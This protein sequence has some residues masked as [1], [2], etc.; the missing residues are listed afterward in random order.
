MTA[1]LKKVMIGLVVA[2]T[3]ASLLAPDAPL[4]VLARVLAAISAIAV[5][6]VAVKGYRVPRSL[7]SHLAHPDP[8][9][10]LGIE[11]GIRAAVDLARIVGNLGE[12]LDPSATVTGALVG[13]ALM[14]LPGYALVQMMHQRFGDRTNDHL[15]EAVIA[16]GTVSLVFWVCIFEPLLRVAGKET[17]DGFSNVIFVTVA[18]VLTSF[19][20][21]LLTSFNE[22]PAAYVALCAARSLQTAAGLTAFAGNALSNGPLS[23]TSHGLPVIAMLLLALGA[24]HPSMA[25]YEEPSGPAGARLNRFRLAALIVPVVLGPLVLT[26]S[27]TGVL[28]VSPLAVAAFTVGLS[29]LVVGHLISMVQARA[30]STHWASHDKLTGLP[31]RAL[32]RERLAQALERS[33]K[34]G[35]SLSVLY[36]DL[37]RFK[38][39]NDSMGHEAG[40]QLLEQVARR[41]LACADSS[42]TV[43]RLGGDEF[44]ILLPEVE[45]DRVP[46]MLARRLLKTFA[47]PYNL[48]PRPV[49]MSPSIGIAVGDASTPLET[50]LTQAD[51]AMYRAK[52]SGR[53]NFAVWSKEMNEAARQRLMLE[54]QLHSVIT[55]DELRLVYQPKVELATGRVVGVE[56]LIRWHHPKLG[57]I[58]PA[59]FIHLA[60]ESGLI[61]Q[62]GE[63]VLETACRQARI[64]YDNGFTSLTMAVNLSSRQFQQQRMADLVS[65][66]LRQ[67][68]LEP[69]LLELELTESVAMSGEG[70]T[71]A[72]L[73]ELREMG[74]KCSID[75]FGTG[76]SNL[77][78]LSRFPIDSLKIDKSFIEQIDKSGGD[79]AIVV[80]IIAMAHGLNLKVIA[81][82]VETPEQAAFLAKHDCDQLQGFLFSKP[83]S[84]AE[85]EGLLM[86][87]HV[88]SG[89]G[90]LGIPTVDAPR[91]LERAMPE[92]DRL[93]PSTKAIEAERRTEARPPSGPDAPPFARRPAAPAPAP[94]Q[95]AFAQQADRAPKPAMA[96]ARSAAPQSPL[97]PAALPEPTRHVG[98]E[99][100]TAP[101]NPEPPGRE[102][103]R[104]RPTSAP[105]P[106]AAQTE[107][108]QSSPPP[109]NTPVR[110]RRFRE[111]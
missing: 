102:P 46:R 43:A 30:S 78:Y 45:D 62:I 103:A 70:I 5:M 12:S 50:L 39:I 89:Q 77:S 57:V 31:N 36:L 75:D 54:T 41:V 49:F 14:L 100:G 10:I 59:V 23:A 32:F 6:A 33:R 83:L 51:T 108:A 72:T 56:A 3:A 22:R 106:P 90:R 40:D 13:A 95:Q 76:Y 79:A 1:L 65:R 74:V 19:A 85:L 37:D 69:H 71:I 21:H 94:A 91:R 29:L 48:K 26:L 4:V 81:E 86:L 96:V 42:D 88:A 18:L 20:V 55:N 47:T 60:E 58:S 38:H 7:K 24:S 111:D 64:W 92:R 105:Q 28:V 97:T 68:G 99:V 93:A 25:S 44:A 15:L 34:T 101:S 107:P 17:T 87:E 11:L 52:E 67:S 82:G 53:N 63:W 66:V 27:L 8:W 16:A 110:G 61:N 84:P 9:I 73:E 2:A 35:A 80:A 98:S 104:M 109:V